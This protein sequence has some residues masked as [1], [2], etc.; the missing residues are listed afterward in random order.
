MYAIR[1]VF[2]FYPWCKL[3]LYY[4][5]NLHRVHDCFIT[6]RSAAV[7]FIWEDIRLEMKDIR[8]ILV[9]NSYPQNINQSL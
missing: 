7:I 6:K 8:L 9:K 1:I 3:N 5:W 2:D 4:L